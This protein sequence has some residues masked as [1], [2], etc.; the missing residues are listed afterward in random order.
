MRRKIHAYMFSFSLPLSSLSLSLPLS[1]ISLGSPPRDTCIHFF[2]LSL[3]LSLLLPLS[4]SL[5]GVTKNLVSQ[6][7]RV[8]Q[9]GILGLGILGLGILGMIVLRSNTQ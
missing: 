1:S 4:F 9:L 8:G 6:V 2:F 5:S 3:P 7:F